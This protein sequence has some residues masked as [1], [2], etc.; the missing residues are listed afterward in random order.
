MGE[1]YRRLAAQATPTAIEGTLHEERG[2]APTS[3]PSPQ[4]CAM[5]AVLAE[6]GTVRES[7]WKSTAEVAWSTVNWIGER[8][9]A[10][11]VATRDVTSRR[12]KYGIHL[13]RRVSFTITELGRELA[14][15]LAGEG[16]LPTGFPT[17]DSPESGPT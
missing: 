15:E 4:F 8:M 14:A 1:L 13:Q 2:S 16:A 17:P 5:L 9:V 11:G 12:S 7:E 10:M 6:V 3:A